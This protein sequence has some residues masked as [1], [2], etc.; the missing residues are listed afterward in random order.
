M[1]AAVDASITRLSLV[2]TTLTFADRE[3]QRRQGEGAARFAARLPALKV[4]LITTVRRDSLLGFGPEVPEACL[5]A[6]AAKWGELRPLLQRGGGR[7][8]LPL[9]QLE[10]YR[11]YL[12]PRMVETLARVQRE[13]EPLQEPMMQLLA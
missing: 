12:T 1:R 7:G 6:F 9:E 2:F 13:S 8:A 4:L 3:E 5:L 11:C 10:L